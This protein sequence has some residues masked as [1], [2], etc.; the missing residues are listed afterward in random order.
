ML[1]GSP[2]DRPLGSTYPHPSPPTRGLLVHVSQK[3]YSNQKPKGGSPLHK[4]GCALAQ[5][6]KDSQTDESQIVPAGPLMPTGESN[7]PLPR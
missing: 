7:G 1:R 3:S 5:L 2:T 4:D 6:A